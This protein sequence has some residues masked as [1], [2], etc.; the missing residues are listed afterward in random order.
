MRLL[1]AD[2]QLPLW[3][4]QLYLTTS[5]AHQVVA[6]LTRLLNDPEANDH[7]HVAALD[8]LREISVSL[9]TPRKLEDLSR[10]TEAE[11]RMFE[12]R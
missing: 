11:R 4:V 5:E 12:E 3:N 6:A 1:D 7:E 9:V 2:Q 8:G 10:Y